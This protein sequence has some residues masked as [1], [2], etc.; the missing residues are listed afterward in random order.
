MIMKYRIAILVALIAIFFTACSREK[1]SYNISKNRVSEGTFTAKVLSP[2]HIRSDYPMVQE[3][4]IPQPIIFK[5]SLNGDDNEGGFGQDHHLIIPQGITEFNAPTLHFGK[6][7]TVPTLDVDDIKEATNVHFRVDMR[8]ILQDFNDPGYTVTPTN[9]TIF[10]S[11]FEGLYLAGGTAPLQW[12]WDNP[13]DLDHLKFQDSDGDSLFELSV[14]FDPDQG[15][16][17]SREWELSTELTAFPE[18]KSPEAPILEALTNMAMEEATLNIRDDGAFS[19]GKEWQGVWTRDFAYASHLSLVYLFPENVRKSL[20]AKLSTDGRIIQDTGTGGSWPI[21]TDRHVWAIAAWEYFLATGDHEWLELI[22]N[23][24]INSLKEDVLWNRDPVSGM[25]QGETS[26]EDWREQTYAPWMSPADIHRSH[27]LSTNVIFKR[28]LEIG[29]G[30]SQEA[31]LSKSWSD[32]ITRLDPAIVDHFWSQKLDAPASYLL[33]SPLWIHAS[34]RDLLGESLG[35]LFSTSFALL[36]SQLVSSYPR[37]DIGSPVI[38]HQLP[39]SPPY[40]NQAIWPFVEAYALLAAKKVGNQAAYS[41]SFNGLIRAAALYLT[42]RENYH[43]L[44]G[45]PDV[46]AI[47]SDRQ[48]WSVGGWLGAI[49]KGL[50]GINIGYDFSRDGFDLMLEPNNPFTWDDHTLSGLKLHGSNISITLKGTGSILKQLTVNGEIMEPGEAI[51]LGKG[52]LDILALLGKGPEGSINLATHTLP[53]IPTARWVQDTLHWESDTELT[54]LLYNGNLLDTL[55]SSP[56]VIPDSLSGFFHL[57][58]ENSSGLRSLPS[59][60]EYL[61]PAAYLVLSDQAPYYIVLNEQRSSLELSFSLPRSGNYILRFLYSNGS[62]AIS[63]GNTCG[64]AGLKINDWWLEQMV[65][66]PHTNS[67][68]QWAFTGWV[69]AVFREGENTLVLD[70]STLPFTNMNGQVNQFLLQ[71]VEIIPLAG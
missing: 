47:N 35:I 61:G 68:D 51:P 11:D 24:V 26:F 38:S 17:G 62:G 14:H 20:L 41:H 58:A 18:F 48:L 27:A 31:G 57:V 56:T 42:H 9:D 53:D 67:W 52:D 4:G 25:L 22:R 23:P 6:R 21:S 8:D 69:K 43:Y 33:A 15:L 29:L 34:H 63:D 54:Y 65:S 71:A 13:G 60:P 49:Y 37:S 1:D 12:I 44:N 32:L 7:A 45:R 40:H 50:F 2:T 66:F 5:L 3:P 70:Q 39:H 30:L 19:A 10:S 46:T 59:Q 28:A 16:T 55:E 36:D 64:L